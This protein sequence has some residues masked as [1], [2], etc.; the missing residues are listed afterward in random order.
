MSDNPADDGPEVP[1]EESP[2]GFLA[3]ALSPVV[4]PDVEADRPSV[5]GEPPEQT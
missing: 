2:R 5:G 3:D 4:D 1:D